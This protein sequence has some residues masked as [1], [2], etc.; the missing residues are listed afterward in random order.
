MSLQA[1]DSPQAD[2]KPSKP[3]RVTGKLRQAC[4]FLVHEGLPWKEAAIKADFTPAAMLY[5]LQRPHVVAFVRQQRDVLRASMCG[6]NI[7]AL[8]E[9]RD[10]KLNQM[11]RVNA[12]LALER[13]DDQQV[14]AGQHRAAPGLTIVI[15]THGPATEL[16]HS[17]AKP[18]ITLERTLPTQGSDEP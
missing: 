3:L 5:A 18:L 1:L 9:V 2:R 8:V 11:A 10:Q 15:E 14:A 17:E 7:L 4:M 13:M 16:R 12:V 6:A